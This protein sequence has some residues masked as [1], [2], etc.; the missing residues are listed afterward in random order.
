MTV[1]ELVK[2][3]IKIRLDGDR[4]VLKGQITDEM[5]E[6]I[7]RNKAVL[8]AE[9]TGRTCSK[10]LHYWRRDLEVG[11]CHVH[12]IIVNAYE[13]CRGWRPWAGHA[14]EGSP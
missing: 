14:L 4:L 2:L 13:D 9:I 12:N 6:D 10:C 11:D 3:G 1:S 8:I 7:R 5:V